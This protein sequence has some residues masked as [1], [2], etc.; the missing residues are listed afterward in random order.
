MG[1]K[2]REQ[3]AVKLGTS[4]DQLRRLSGLL[5]GGRSGAAGIGADSAEVI[6]AQLS[7]TPG[8]LKQLRAAVNG[9]GSV[10]CQTRVLVQEVMER[11]GRTIRPQSAKPAS[12]PRRPSRPVSPTHAGSAAGGIAL[13]ESGSLFTAPSWITADRPRSVKYWT[14]ATTVFVTMWGDK[15]HLYADCGGTRPPGEAN[16]SMARQVPLSDRICA[17]RTGCLKCFGQFW[18]GPSL[19][20]LKTLI[21]RLHGRIDESPNRRTRS[22]IAEKIN[23]RVG[24]STPGQTSASK[25][26]PSPALG[27][28]KVTSAGKSRPP[29]PKTGLAAQSQKPIPAQATSAGKA[30]AKRQRDQMEAARL[31]ITEAE[32]KARRRAENDANR[33]KKAR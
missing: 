8:Q 30:A 10:N 29:K 33:A 27:R 12:S 7:I 9:A 3:L 17:A 20:E 11:E 31:G 23:L 5:S 25:R 18:S 19:A 1:A 26:L 32:L 28:S 2:E 16:R 13:P 21:D 15:V 24:K 14:P 22:I 4:V 6:A